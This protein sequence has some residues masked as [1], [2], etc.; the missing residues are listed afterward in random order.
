MWLQQRHWGSKGLTC[1]DSK[2]AERVLY[3]LL[4]DPIKRGVDYMERNA[5][6]M[7]LELSTG[8]LQPD[9]FS[10]FIMLELTGDK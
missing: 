9:N 8:G 4:G 6:K 10:Q 5:G 2:E 1:K 7:I 3:N